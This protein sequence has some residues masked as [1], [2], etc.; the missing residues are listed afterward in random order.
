MLKAEY[1]TVSGWQAAIR[2][3]RNP[4]DSWAK[5]D[6][7]FYSHGH[8]FDILERPV[9]WYNT[10]SGE[11]QSDVYIGVKDLELMCILSDAGDE[12]AKF[13]RMINVTMDIT[14]PLYWW[15]EFD[16]YKIGTVA[17]SCS[18]MHR[19]HAKKFTM[20]DFSTE[21]L[22]SEEDWK[23]DD[24]MSTDDIL[25]MSDRYCATY[26]SPH[27]IMSWT[28]LVLNRARELY[29]ET[30]D[31][32]YWW[33]M[34]QLLPSSYNQKRTVQMN[35][36]VLQRIYHQRKNHKLDEWHTLCDVIKD[37]PYAA[38]II[39]ECEDQDNASDQID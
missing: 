22:L 24:N 7:L 28:L 2:G 31:K 30:N 21:H 18:T 35:Y 34:I 6:S 15:K 29:L 39:Y 23:K 25:S 17:N 37:L 3:M 32:K 33:Q 36:Q 13:M 27:N 10:D 12:H 9:L 19:I 38:W 1:I 11:E 4:K 5:S 20:D 16:T 8:G 14:A 26:M